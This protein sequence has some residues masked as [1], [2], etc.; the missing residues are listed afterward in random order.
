[1]SV[2]EILDRLDK[3]E[4]ELEQL[5]KKENRPG[6]VQV[7]S[8]P[9]PGYVNSIE[10]ILF[11]ELEK[12][13]AYS[14]DLLVLAAFTKEG[15]KPVDGMSIASRS[16]RDLG[17][18]EDPE[19]QARL[20][21]QALDVLQTMSNE[22]RLRILV[23]TFRGGKYPKELT[24]ATGLQGGALYHHLDVL[25]EAGFL[26]RNEQGKVILT[27]RGKLMTNL[28]SILSRVKRWEFS[29]RTVD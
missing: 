14:E 7:E 6:N 23:E 19:K 4:K 21:K 27:S 16:S 29:K 13:D 22:M 1:M 15:G 28:I 18:T 25:T 12:S 11:E 8:G 2:N 5:K 10:R 3:V 17:E 20:I 24:M 26:E 9:P